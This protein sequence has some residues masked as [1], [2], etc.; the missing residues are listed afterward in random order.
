MNIKL[1]KNYLFGVIFGVA[2]C[3][4][5]IFIFALIMLIF[6]ID[7][8]YA[9]FFGTISVAFGAYV[10]AFY[11]AKKTGSKGYLTGII[12]GIAYFAVITLLSFVV[13]KENIGSNTAFHFI[14]IVL[15]SAVGGIM[16][17]NTKK[18]KII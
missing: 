14:I 2:A 8:A 12:T 16:G 15:S 17:V 18:T 7:R 10:S 3:V 13:T 5:S 9:A 1:N 11:I 4:I 6:K